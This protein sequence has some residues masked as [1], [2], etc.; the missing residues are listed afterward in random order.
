M[1]ENDSHDGP[2][3]RGS[4]KKNP[5]NKPN[6]SLVPVKHPPTSRRALS[7]SQSYSDYTTPPRHVGPPKAG[8]KGHSQSDWDVSSRAKADAV[9]A[10]TSLHWY[11]GAAFDRSPAAHTLP[12][13]TKLLATRE[14][15]TMAAKRERTEDPATRLMATSCPSSDPN[16]RS[17]PPL[18]SRGRSKTRVASPEQ[19]SQ[20][21][22]QA[23]SQDLLR[24]LKGDKARTEIMKEAPKN[25]SVS[26]LAREATCLQDDN[27]GTENAAGDRDVNELTRQVR[28]LLNLPPSSG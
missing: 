4:P 18:V 13:P 15:S 21:D 16:P 14:S 2:K 8:S 5:K 22:L 26:P 20:V 12:H 3:R 24:I 27:I 19:R 23:K 6:G 7:Q 25:P 10:S 17:T 11:A 1:H 9:F 28:R